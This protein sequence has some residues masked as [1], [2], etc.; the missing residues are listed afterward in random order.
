MGAERIRLAQAVRKTCQIDPHRATQGMGPRIMWQAPAPVKRAGTLAINHSPHPIN[1]Q[2]TKV[3]NWPWKIAAEGL[4]GP[5]RKDIIKGF[6]GGIV[7]QAHYR[8]SGGGASLRGFRHHPRSP[9]PCGHKPSHQARRS[10]RAFLWP[11][12]GKRPGVEPSALGTDLARPF[13]PLLPSPSRA[14]KK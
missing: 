6:D 13:A 1:L 8:G 14:E 11:D 7:E 12:P 10:A 9:Q 4:S 2:I 5:S 3:E